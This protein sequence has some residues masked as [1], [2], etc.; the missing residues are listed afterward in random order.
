MGGL[1]R[2]WSGIGRVVGLLGLECNRLC[3]VICSVY[4]DLRFCEGA[5]GKLHNLLHF[6]FRRRRIWGR[7]S[8]VLVRAWAELCGGERMDGAAR[9]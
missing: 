9:W 4:R 2:L 6:A 7:W 8:L 5:E 3:R 1:G